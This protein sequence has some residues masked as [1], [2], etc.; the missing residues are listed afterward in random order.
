MT[1]DPLLPVAPT[2]TLDVDPASLRAEARRLRQMAEAL[3]RQ[4]ERSTATPGRVDDWTGP[5]ARSVKKE[6]RALGRQIERFLPL[7]EES[8]RAVSSLADAYDEGLEDLQALKSRVVSARGTYE[9][10]SPQQ[11]RSLLPPAPVVTVKPTLLD[12]ATAR[13]EAASDLRSGYARISS[14][15]GALVERL[16]RRTTRAAEELGS[17]VP[18]VSDSSRG[19]GRMGRWAP[20]ML[21][22]VSAVAAARAAAEEDLPLTEER[23]E[24]LSTLQTPPDDWREVLEKFHD[25]LPDDLAY[26]PVATWRAREDLKLLIEQVDDLT[27]AER[28]EEVRRWS[29]TRDDATLGMLALVEPDL[30]GNL[31]G[32]PYRSRYVANHMR[33]R[34]AL[35]VEKKHLADMR[36]ITSPHGEWPEERHAAARIRTLKTM[37]AESEQILVFE[38]ARYDPSGLLL[39]YEGTIAVVKG[40]LDEADYVATVAPGITN[41]LE[42]FGN[43]VTRAANVQNKDADVATIAWTGY[44][45]PGLDPSMASEHKAEVGAERLKD[46]IEGL[47]LDPKVELSIV[48]HSYGTL[49]TAKAL[50]K[51]LD[52]DRVIFMGS[53]GLGDGVK[54]AADL[55]APEHT[56]F[57]ALDAPGDA[58]TETAGHGRN[59]AKMEGIV[60]LQVFDPGQEEGVKG[61]SNYTAEKTRSLRQVIGVVKGADMSQDCFDKGLVREYDQRPGPLD[62]VGQ[63]HRV[64]GGAL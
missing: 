47:V 20:D 18:G 4:A 25:D 61:H 30:V 6:M 35:E 9:R 21:K 23:L 26:R 29:S 5:G 11:D 54:T 57:Y 55:K 32:F 44:D 59:P 50:Q 15:H 41:N 56:R 52:V 19:P 34:T 36:R 58:V 10:V 62:T 43:I 24:D 51:G 27:P 22:V 38:P 60:P 45:T 13:Q 7:L 49:T 63:S 42:N 3:Q 2:L 33:V 53:P 28:A 64:F 16:R 48:A 12:G 40:D 37:L 39:D 17:A 14:D 8:A 46:F 31:E 1:L